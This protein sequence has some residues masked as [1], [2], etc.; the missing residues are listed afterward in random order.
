VAEDRDEFVGRTVELAVMRRLQAEAAEGRPQ[1][2]LV[3]GPAGIGKTS[4]IEQFLSEV[5]DTAILRASGEPWEAFVAFGV[6]DQLVRAAGVRGG[7]LL[8]SRQRALPAEEPVGVGAVLLESL[9][10][11]ERKSAVILLV[12]DAHWA[13][14]DSLRALLFALRRLVTARVLTVLSV[15]DEDATRFPDGL[16]RMASGAT[17]R[18]LHL[19]A[20]ETGEVRMLATALGV[21]QFHMRTARRLRDHTGGN[22]LY[23]RA[24]LSELPVDRWST[25]QPQ[26]PAPR[27]FVTQVLAR[28]SSCSPSAR[29]LAEACSV[30]GVRSSLPMA[31]A[32]AQLDDAVE[33]LDEAVAVGLLQSTD[34]IDFWDVAFPHPL[35]QAA[36]YEH[37]SPTN[38][39]RLHRVASELVDDAGAALRHRVAATTPPNDEVAA[40]LDA[41][42][43][44]EMRWG[45]WAGAAAALVEASRMSVDRAEREE[46]L[47]R[48]IDAI[49]SAGDLLQA[50]AFLRDVAKFE[51]GPLR[52]AAL[53][54]LAILRGRAVE[55]E[56]LLGAG[57]ARSDPAVDP[58]L[59]ALLALRWTLHSVGRLQG[60]AIVEWSRRAVALVPDDDATRLESE[61][62]LGLGLGLMGRVPEGLAAYTSVLAPMTGAEGSTAG[63]VG[64]AKSWLQLVVDDLDGVPE[65]LADLAPTQLR[66]GSVRIAVWS[67]VWL[68][69]AHYLLGAWTDAIAAAERAVSLLEETGHDWLRPLARWVAV[70]VYASRG[71]WAA[72]ETH[73][74]RAAT[75]SGDY[76]LMI[77]AAALAKADLASVRGDH[78]QVLD[79]L[80]PLHTIQPREGIDE[81]GFWPWQH[82]YGDALIAAGRLEEAAAFL[83]PHEKLAQDLNRRS[84]V[85]RLARVRGR[86]EGVAGRMEAAEAAFRYGIEQLD[87]LSLPFER[88]ALDL[89]YGQMLRRRGHRRAAALRLEAAQERFAA[90]GARP[91]VERCARELKGSGLAPAKRS[92]ADPAR[93]TPQE[94]TVARLAATGMSN[95]DIASEMA[96][97]AKT[98]QFHVGNVYAKL[99]VRSRLQLAHRLGDTWTPGRPPGES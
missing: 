25:W 28:L 14:V 16:R 8:A 27:A 34:K 64:M 11:L 10:R 13:D 75:E 72:A 58:H 23:V 81:P 63:R 31:A 79:A 57:W 84:A 66:D 90:L 76:E 41:F 73:V 74:E 55:A 98:V 50:S 91:Y 65:T 45:A 94:L 51:P 71:E 53:G 20:L 36:V 97:S 37:V 4:L 47:L 80:E 85:A 35:I 40:A 1:T 99:G 62:I 78:E 22:P 15:R 92:N 54:Y 12:D 30:L 70:E 44:R 86:L 96:I 7:L 21:P 9:E 33:T 69:R 49:V 68:S 95:R 42:A 17:G 29:A 60:G 56:A 46:R 61:A 26:L 38:R 5:D 32:L 88:A 89:A 19:A 93:L 39:V 48:A 52:D 59:A 6:V 77:V 2:V 24:L 87:G 18:S 83:A 43:R 82:L 67:Y 3:T